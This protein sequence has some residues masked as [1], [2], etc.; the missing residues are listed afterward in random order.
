MQLL[1]QSVGEIVFTIKICEQSYEDI[2]R[3]LC[4]SNREKIIYLLSKIKK[5]EGTYAALL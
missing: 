3:K 2:Y 1:H 4:T 5:K